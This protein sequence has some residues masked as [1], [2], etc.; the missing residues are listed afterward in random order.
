MKG[1]YKLELQMPETLKL[2]DSSK[3]LRYKTKNGENGVLKW[4][5][6]NK[7]LKSYIFLCPINF[8]LIY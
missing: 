4:L 2:F 6:I 3:K 1:G 5:N 8:M 7:S